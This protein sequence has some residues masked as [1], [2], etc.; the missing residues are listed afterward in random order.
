MVYRRRLPNALSRLLEC[1]L[2]ARRFEGSSPLLVLGDLPLA[3]HAPQTVFVQTP[4]LTAGATRGRWLD[5]LKFAIA[6]WVFRRNA[7]R[8]RA[9]IVQ[10]PVMKAALIEAHPE[11]ADRVH[12]IAQPVPGWLLNAGIARI[13]RRRPASA[14]LSLVYPAALYPHKNHRLLGSLDAS[15]DWPVESFT[16]TIAPD[17]SPARG[18]AWLKCIGF[19]SPVR[20]LDLYREA[21][22]LVFLS[23]D[24]SY[25]FPLVEAMFVGLPIVCSDLP[26]A[27]TLCGDGAIYFDPGSLASL[28]AAIETLNVR[29]CAG[30]WPDWT[31][32]RSSFPPDWD[33]VAR[34]MSAIA[35]NGVG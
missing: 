15:D 13:G 12:V 3:C 8:A 28:K 27:R 20:M 14:G 2:L 7:G 26:Y 21:D 24:E 31:A 30:W 32:Q 22:A 16:L 18:I 25:G 29:L 17:W 19:V 10:T 5:G 9:F 6:R 23:T 1:T 34:S 33:A 35:L 11:I 4:H